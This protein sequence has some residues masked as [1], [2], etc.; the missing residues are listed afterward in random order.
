MTGLKPPDVEENVWGFSSGCTSA[1]RSLYTPESQAPSSKRVVSPAKSTVL[2]G[3]VLMFAKVMEI[4]IMVLHFE[5]S[6]IFKFPLSE[7]CCACCAPGDPSRTTQERLRRGTFRRRRRLMASVI[8][9]CRSTWPRASKS[10]VS[11]PLL[12]Q[13]SKLPGL[14]RGSERCI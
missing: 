9:S 1:V 7:D 14:E 10:G 6:K 12:E 11:L 8:S 3:Q 5:I 2:L 13:G 4:R